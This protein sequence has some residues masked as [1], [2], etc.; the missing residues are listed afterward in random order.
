MRAD[1]FSF[2]EGHT[3]IATFEKAPVTRK[4]ALHGNTPQAEGSAV[5]SKRVRLDECTSTP[6]PHGMIC[7]FTRPFI[8]LT[9]SKGTVVPPCLSNGKVTTRPSI[10]KPNHNVSPLF[11]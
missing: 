5:P 10:S 3:G 6:C 2:D 7:L 8:A 4:R 1:Y 11:D 9:R